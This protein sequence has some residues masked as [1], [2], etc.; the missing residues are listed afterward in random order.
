MLMTT[1]IN[2]SAPY[3]VAPFDVLLVKME[4][5]FRY[6]AKRLMRRKGRGLDF[7]DVM[8][9]LR[10]LALELYTSAVRRGKEVFFSPILNFAI[11]KYRAGRRFTGYN[12]TDIHS[13]ETQRLG[14]S[15]LHQLSVFDS[16]Q[17]TKELDTREFMEDRRVNV[18]DQ[19]QFKVDFEDWHY[20]QSPRDQQII[21]DLAMGETTNAVAKK[22]GVSASL[23]S[24]KRKDFAKSWKMFLDPPEAGMLVPA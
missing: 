24:I 10:G 11:K 16:E 20:N 2:T 14:R 4:P 23:I 15:K 13:E 9:D 18:A 12:S 17:R 5:H 22:C 1:I 21:D 19:V 3:H 7:D 8:Q 6:Y